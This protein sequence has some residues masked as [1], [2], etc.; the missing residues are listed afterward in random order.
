MYVLYVL[1]TNLEYSIPFPQEIW[2]IDGMECGFHIH[3]PPWNGSLE[4]T[5]PNIFPGGS[6]GAPPRE[7]TPKWARRAAASLSLSFYLSISLCHA[8]SEIRV[9]DKSMDS[10]SELVLLRRGTDV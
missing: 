7:D 8:L 6:G 1:H 9:E 5:T 4:G 2:K 10:P 3:F